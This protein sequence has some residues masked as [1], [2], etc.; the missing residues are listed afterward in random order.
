C[1]PL[2]GVENGGML[3]R[4]RDDPVAAFIGSLDGAFK[5]PVDRLGGA[6]G[7]CD[8]SAFQ[9]GGPFDLLARDLDDRRGLMAPARRRMRIREFL[10]DPRMHRFRDF[11]SERGRRLVVEVDHAALAAARSAMRRHSARKRSTSASLVEGPKLIRRNPAATLAGTPIAARTALP[12]IA[13]DEHALPAETAIPTRSN[14]TS[15]DALAA[16]GSET[17]P[18]VGTRELSSAMT[19]PPDPFTPASS[20]ALSLASRSRSQ[21]CATSAAANASALGASCVPRR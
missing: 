20:R 21:G 12:F 19:T 5:G 17:A 16:P 14:C 9:T 7:E 10:L 1:E 13:P 15:S 3:S 11:R 8:A 6:A 2:A 4:N 18:I